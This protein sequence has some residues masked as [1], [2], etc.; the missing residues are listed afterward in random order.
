VELVKDISL[1]PMK[2]KEEEK[3]GQK[4]QEEEKVA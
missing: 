1:S 4:V 2:E 3:D